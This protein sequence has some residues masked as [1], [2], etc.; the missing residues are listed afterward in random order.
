MS[1]THRRAVLAEFSHQAE[2]FN[3]S[4]T[5]TS[6]QTLQ[7]LVD[8]L[9]AKAGERWLEVPCGPGLVARGL[10]ERGGEVVAGDVTPRMLA[11]GRRAARG[12]GLRSVRY[13]AAAATSLPLRAGAV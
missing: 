6:D 3:R 2:A 12:A 13:V 10:A 8:L 7:A 1:A 11:L 9:P 5:M 4:P